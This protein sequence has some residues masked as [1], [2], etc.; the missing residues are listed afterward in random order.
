MGKIFVLIISILLFCAVMLVLGIVFWGSVEHPPKNSTSNQSNIPSINTS[1]ISEIKAMPEKVDDSQA[2]DEDTLAVASANNKFATNFYNE[3][4][5]NEG[6][7]FYSPYSISSALAM[8][9]EGAEGA[10]KEEMKSVFY[11]PEQ[12]QMRKGNAA[13]Y[14]SLNKKGK[15]YSL[16]TANALWAEKTC[17][18]SQDYFSTIERYYGGRITNMDFITNSEQ[19]RQTINYWVEEQ[20]NNKIKDLLSPG[21]IDSST[22][23]VLTNAIY[24]KGSWKTE[25]K[26]ED[27]EQADFQ[28][29]SGTVKADMMHQ[30]NNFN[31]AE[32]SGLKILEMD[33]TEDLSML[34]LLPDNGL[35]TIDLTSQHL[36]SWKSNLKEREVD[37]YFPK[38]KF[39]TKYSLKENLKNM[40]M[41]TAFSDGADFSGMTGGKDLVI[42]EV[43][44]QAF[45]EVN[46][47]G[48]EAAAA[49]GVVMRVTSAGPIDTAVFRADHPFIFIIQEKETGNILFMG[50][51]ENPSA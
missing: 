39:E 24:F 17:A 16:S 28:T 20:T 8:T 2:S 5:T 51:V 10:T 41:P 29:T 21:I 14:N 12:E 46:E 30:N 44:H 11:F 32:L 4:K 25:F 18:F 45:V 27:T 7:L 37:V 9:Y 13:V 33:Y 19:S 36:N 50:R 31:Y 6:N 34:I 35:N 40:G 22:R 49:T 38:F 42:S 1:V 15:N 43:I 47:Q 23:L 3:I 48:T 26:E